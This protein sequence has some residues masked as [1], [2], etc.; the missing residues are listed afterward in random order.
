MYSRYE[1][2]LM[3]GYNQIKTDNTQLLQNKLNKVQLNQA[4]NKPGL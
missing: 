2:Q 1:R 3:A 4:G